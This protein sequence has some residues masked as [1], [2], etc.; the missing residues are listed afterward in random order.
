MI[1]EIGAQSV[2]AIEV[3][4]GAAPV[5]SDTRHLAW[6]RDELGERFLTGVVLHTGRATFELG[7]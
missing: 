3:K 4:A 2:V 1:A 5:A 7:Y 6:P